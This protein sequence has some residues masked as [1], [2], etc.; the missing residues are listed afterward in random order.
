MGL[1]SP[2]GETPSPASQ[3]V[4]RP[5]NGLHE[6]WLVPPCE[7]HWLNSCDGIKA[8]RRYLQATQAPDNHS[9]MWGFPRCS[10]NQLNKCPRTRSCHL[11]LQMERQFSEVLKERGFNGERRTRPEIQLQGHEKYYFSKTT[12][13]TGIFLPFFLVIFLSF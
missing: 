8:S 2:V 7:G 4:V 13:L 12:S 11:F 3:G 1:C 5:H 6:G 9:Q 10:R